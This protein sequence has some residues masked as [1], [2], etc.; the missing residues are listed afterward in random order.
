MR[1]LLLLC[2]SSQ[3]TAASFE[4]VTPLLPEEAASLNGDLLIGAFVAPLSGQ[5]FIHETD[6]QVK[7]AQ[8]LLLQRSYVSPQ[9]LGRYEDKEKIDS[10]LLAK[11]LIGQKSKNWVV[12]PH[13]T[14]GFNDHS[15]LKMEIK[16]GCFLMEAGSGSNEKKIHKYTL[17][18]EKTLAYFIKQIKRGKALSIITPS[19]QDNFR[20]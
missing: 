17:E 3:L 10:Y 7:G 18:M 13:V 1:Y 9:I 15:P 11:A 2:L 8:D 5:V 19:V 4:E 14:A 16:Q 12:H 20:K 6:L